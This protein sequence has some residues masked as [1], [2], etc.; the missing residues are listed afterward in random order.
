MYD[1][2]RIVVKTKHGVG[3]SFEMEVDVHQGS[4]LSPILFVVVIEALRCEIR[5]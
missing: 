1:R 2:A 3:E 4:V 5:E